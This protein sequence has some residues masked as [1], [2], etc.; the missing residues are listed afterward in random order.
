VNTQKLHISLTLTFG[1]L[2]VV[3]ILTLMGV[4]GSGPSIT[5]AQID[6]DSD[7]ELSVTTDIYTNVVYLPFI[8]KPRRP[9]FVGL[10]LRWDG[11]GYIR[12]SEYE[13]IGTHLQ[14]ECNSMTD[15]D[16]IKCHSY[17]WY[18]P[19]PY[20]WDSEDW[21]AYYSISTGRFKSSSAPAD[22][23]WKWGYPWIVPY[24]VQFSDG[25]TV[26]VDGQAFA[27]S[28]PHSGYT[29]FGQ[30]V[31]YWLLVNKDK[32]LFW[33]GGG[34]WTQYVHQGDVTLWYDAGHTRLLLHDDVLRRYYHK[35]Q[36]TS[37]TVQYII[38]LTSSNAF[39]DNEAILEELD[40]SK[41]STSLLGRSSED[42]AEWGPMHVPGT[43]HQ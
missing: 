32:F 14:K 3:G 23:S 18:D 35:E 38:N 29:A 42:V 28:G 22:P 9:L 37:D 13:N 4:L 17:H 25:Q 19:N 20:S 11:N 16:T 1:L 40:H 39:S 7:G 6:R 41:L 8:A 2:A 33:D 5:L 30:P 43:L 36:Q 34:D 15:D 27:V 26:F 12:G 21:D 31:Q 10:Q 24:D